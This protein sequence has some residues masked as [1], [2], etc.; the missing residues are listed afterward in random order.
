MYLHVLQPY[1]T[2]LETARA[3]EQCVRDNGAVPA[4]VALIDGRVH[5]G[6][7]DTE[8][9]RLATARPAEVRVIRCAI[10]A[11]ASWSPESLN[12]S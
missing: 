4:T 7:T 9:E 11:K 3:V 6:L 5:I 2:N 1:P 10:P 8:L 12:A